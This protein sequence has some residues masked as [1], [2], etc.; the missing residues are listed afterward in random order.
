MDIRD[1][2]AYRILKLLSDEPRQTPQSLKERLDV[3]I[4]SIKQVL[5]ILYG[6]KLVDRVSRGLY[7]ITPIG[8]NHLQRLT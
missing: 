6:L 3:S 4:S 2:L 1:K 7:V 5:S 8:R